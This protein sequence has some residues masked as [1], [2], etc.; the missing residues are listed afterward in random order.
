ML[1]REAADVL[2]SSILVPAGLVSQF[3][4]PYPGLVVLPTEVGDGSHGGV[5]L[6]E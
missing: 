2:P 3:C 1:H 6:N 4:V 5:I